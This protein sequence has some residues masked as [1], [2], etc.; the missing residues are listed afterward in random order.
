MSNLLTLV[1]A[2][3]FV[4]SETDVHDKLLNMLIPMVSQTIESYCDRSF[5]ATDYTEYYDG[6]GSAHL[7]VD[8]WPINSVSA[9]Y[10]DTTRQFTTSSLIEDVNYVIYANEGRITLIGSYL[11]G[12]SMMDNAFTSGLQNIKIIYN[13]GYVA[14]PYDL[15]LIAGEV[16]AKKWKT[17]QDKRIGYSSIS[18]QG[19]SFVMTVSD[20]LPEHLRILNARYRKRGMI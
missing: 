4:R 2:K 15:R 7:Y 14:I 5:D 1:E 20:L 6:E 9:L 3:I 18:T 8:N 19:E 11:A 12:S 16:L 13:A 17:Y 10:N